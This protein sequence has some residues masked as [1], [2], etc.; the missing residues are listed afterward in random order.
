[1]QIIK[2]KQT[3]SLKRRWFI[4]IYFTLLV[5]LA[6]FAF[7]N[8]AILDFINSFQTGTFIGLLAGIIFISPLLLITKLTSHDATIEL[9]EKQLKVSEKG[10]D[11]IVRYTDIETMYMHRKRLN[12]LELMD[13]RRTLLYTFWP[14]NNGDVIEELINFLSKEIS[15]KKAKK[16]VKFRGAHYDSVTFIRN[17]RSN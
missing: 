8:D 7:T 13:S 10:K 2:Y 5:T 16:V 4:I 1:M 6:I 12:V 14:C 15:F 3:D 17:M 11:V 9:D